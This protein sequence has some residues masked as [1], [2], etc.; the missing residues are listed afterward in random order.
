MGRNKENKMDI[1]ERF[2]FHSVNHRKQYYLHFIDS[3]RIRNVT[4]SIDWIAM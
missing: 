4:S 3:T 2:Q 1:E